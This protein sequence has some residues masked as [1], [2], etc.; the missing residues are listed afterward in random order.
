M[1]KTES[2]EDSGRSRP[3]W[4]PGRKNELGQFN[5]FRRDNFAVSRA[6]PSLSRREYYKIALLVGRTRIHYADRTV[7]TGRVSLRFSNPQIPY[8]WEY[9][10]DTQSGYFCVFT[11]AFFSRFGSLSDYPVFLPGH[12]HVFAVADDQWEPLAALFRRMQEEISSEYPYKDDVLRML[13]FDL[14]HHALKREPAAVLRPADSNASRRIATLFTE[15]LERQFPVES[16]LQRMSLRTP[17]EFAASLAVHVNHLNRSLREVTGKTTSR[18]IAERIGQEARI[19][20]K[21]TTWNI[22]EIAFCLGYGE[23]GHFIHF[24]R[25]Q[26]GETP[27]AFRLRQEV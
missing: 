3:L 26:F 12:D 2:V 7:E 5:V 25:K 4:V 22:S 17:V 21:Q 6:K 10:D 23:P 14:V 20:L 27:K 24:F 19:L 11:P 18:L 1:A 9:L 8:W 15:L 13:T 16:P